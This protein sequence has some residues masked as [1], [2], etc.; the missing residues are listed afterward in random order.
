MQQG[1]AGKD[2][3]WRGLTTARR[4]SSSGCCPRSGPER[5]GVESMGE[6]RSGKD[7]HGLLSA[8]SWFNEPILR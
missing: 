8:G 5:T 2:G 3:A 1:E 6:V 7:W 4:G